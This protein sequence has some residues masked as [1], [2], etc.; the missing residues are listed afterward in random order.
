MIH[1]HARR[2]RGWAHLCSDRIM[3]ILRS[4]RIISLGILLLALAITAL[5]IYVHA[6]VL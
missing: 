3:A 6:L 5:R 2:I 1:E 4:L